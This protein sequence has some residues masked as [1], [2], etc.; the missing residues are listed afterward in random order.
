MREGRARC[1]SRVKRLDKIEKWIRPARARGFVPFRVPRSRAL[2]QRPSPRCS[3]SKSFGTSGVYDG[4]DFE[5]KRGRALVSARTQHGAGK[6]DAVRWWPDTGARLGRSAL[7][8]AAQG[9]LLLADAARL[10]DTELACGRR[11]TTRSAGA[12][13]SKRS[14]LGSFDFPG[15][16]IRQDISVLWA[17]RDRA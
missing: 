8:A 5:I 4:S 10:L 6:V 13:P 14:L 15:D 16:E 2:G 17:A 9:R 1:Q 7:G 3:K 11:S 12:K